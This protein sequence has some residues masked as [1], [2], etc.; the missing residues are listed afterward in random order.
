[1]PN[2]RI[3]ARSEIWT[4][5]IAEPGLTAV[6]VIM[7]AIGMGANTAIFSVVNAVLIRP[8]E[9]PNPGQIVVMSSWWQKDGGSR[10]GPRAGLSRLA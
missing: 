2:D 4:S 7:L 3:D 1:M 9:H 5:P 8:L 6:V 10:A